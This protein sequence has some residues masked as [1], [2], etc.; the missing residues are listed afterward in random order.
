[1]K[2]VKFQLS[3]FG[4]NTYIVF[5]PATNEAAIIDPGMIN[6]EEQTAIRNFITQNNLHLKYIINTHLHIDHV[7]GNKWAQD[8]YHVPTMAH[9]DDFKLGRMLG[10]QAQAFGLPLAMEWKESE[11]PLHDGEVINIGRGRLKVLHVPGHS[12]GSV[13]LYDEEDGFLISGDALFAG[14]IGRTDLPGGSMP[15]LLESIR[16]KLFT[17]PEDVMVYPGHGAP[18]TIGREKLT[19]PFFRD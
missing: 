7:A 8:T 4:I 16:T 2:I 13:A 17:L 10:A 1:M 9:I 5:D 6:T 14:S 3:L 19:N 12:R 18:T 11:H 15:Q